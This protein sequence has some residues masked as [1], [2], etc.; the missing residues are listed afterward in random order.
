MI[1]LMIQNTRSQVVARWQ[2]LPRSDCHPI[3]GVAKNSLGWDLSH[4]AI[5]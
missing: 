5:W 2:P 1:A 4:F 3:H